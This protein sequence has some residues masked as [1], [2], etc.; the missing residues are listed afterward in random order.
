MV[1]DILY[2]KEKCTLIS[3][4]KR[5]VVFVRNDCLFVTLHEK[6]IVLKCSSYSFLL[7]KVF[8]F[9]SFMCFWYCF[10]AVHWCCVQ[11]QNLHRVYHARHRSLQETGP[12]GRNQRKPNARWGLCW[13]DFNDS[14]LYMMQV[15]HICTDQLY[16]VK[17]QVSEADKLRN[18]LRN[19][20][21][22]SQVTI[23]L[24][25]LLSCCLW[26]RTEHFL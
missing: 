4:I 24:W 8:L 7:M 17:V 25:L 21:D 26:A 10:N 13:W 9:Q 6:A 18:R 16:W 22:N 12:G 5:F 2:I 3:S 20:H 14:Y 15:I 11:D 19:E 23:L 1:I